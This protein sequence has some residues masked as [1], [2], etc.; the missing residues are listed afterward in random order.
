MTTYW[1]EHWVSGQITV[2][3]CS[4][5]SIKEAVCLLSDLHPKGVFRLQSKQTE[6][7]RSHEN[8]K[9]LEWVSGE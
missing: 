6:E 2:E 8:L 7:E 1:F 9:E 4:A 3:V 5:N